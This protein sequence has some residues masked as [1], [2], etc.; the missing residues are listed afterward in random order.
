MRLCAQAAAHKCILK[1]NVGILFYI[2]RK[3]VEKRKKKL[4]HT[5]STINLLP[6]FM[7]G[8]PTI[9]EMINPEIVIPNDTKKVVALI[10]QSMATAV[11][12]KSQHLCKGANT[13]KSMD[14]VKAVDYCMASVMA[15][16]AIS[17]GARNTLLFTNGFNK[18]KFEDFEAF[19][20]KSRGKKSANQTDESTLTPKTKRGVVFG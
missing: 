15:K 9:A 1:Y 13:L 18:Y 7:K 14:I 10:L 4:K 2:P 19:R 20:K 16:H 11:A 12:E 3:K 5:H 8:I 17:E 6:E